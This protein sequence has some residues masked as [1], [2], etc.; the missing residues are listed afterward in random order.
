MDL[1]YHPISFNEALEIL[2]Q[3]FSNYMKTS[4]DAFNSL[5]RNYMKARFDY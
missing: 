4:I 2:S 5:K 3:T 1:E